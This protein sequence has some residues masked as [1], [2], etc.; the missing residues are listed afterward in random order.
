MTAE[1]SSPHKPSSQK[2]SGNDMKPNLSNTI[3][4]AIQKCRRQSIV[5]QFET[6][7]NAI[8]NP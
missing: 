2:N 3:S 1:P 4:A 8:S 7:F 5:F 6:R